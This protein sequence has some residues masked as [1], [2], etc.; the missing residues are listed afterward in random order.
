VKR[1][2]IPILLFFALCPVFSSPLRLGLYQTFPTGVGDVVT[3]ALEAISSFP[4]ES[5]TLLSLNRGRDE[6]AFDS[7]SLKSVHDAYYNEKD[8]PDA[9]EFEYTPY[10]YGEGVIV[11]IK[12]ESYFEENIADP[13]ALLYMLS[14]ND[15]DMLFILS[16]SSMGQ[17]VSYEL[18][19]YDGEERIP[20]C[21]GIV[22][23]GD[24]RNALPD[25]MVS[26][27]RIFHPGKG[28]LSSSRLKV[29]TTITIDGIALD[30]V[31]D[32]HLL[33]EGAYGLKL[34]LYG[35]EDEYSVIEVKSGEI[36]YPES[37]MKE[38]GARAEHI[39]AVPSFATI[40]VP[41]DGAIPSPLSFNLT[42]MAP[43]TVSAEGFMPSSRIMGKSEGATLSV[44]SLKPEWMDDADRLKDSK[45]SMYRSL[46]NALISVGFIAGMT[47]IQNIYPS[48]DDDVINPIKVT[49]T[50]AG[51]VLVLDFLR[52]CA[53]YYETAKETYN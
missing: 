31:E 38:L 29:G 44:I 14:L 52:T 48:R 30:M 13:D 28:L 21:S 7:T 47:A 20:V 34:T 46:R 17:L 15:L 5:Q 39:S 25:V 36:A 19:A 42:G 6:R 50:G 11:N 9:K 49:V 45:K 32:F 3:T 37:A 23:E 40:S 16:G 4:D 12:S 18:N 35:H 1:G 26:L 41:G 27:V 51:I 22:R 53:E 8:I 2:I 33:D 43:Y 10:T 24:E